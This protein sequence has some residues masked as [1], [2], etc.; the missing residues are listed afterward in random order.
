MTS[1]VRIFG[2][3]AVAATV[4]SSL[5]VLGAAL[6]PWLRTGNATRSAFGLARSASVLGLF[7]GA[8]RRVCLALWY[9]LPFL[10]AATW[11]AGAARRP[12][13]TALLGGIVGLTSLVAGTLV[14]VLA[15][16]APGPVVAIG[17]GAAAIGSAVLLARGTMRA[18]SDIFIQEGATT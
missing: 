7:D 8:P 11:T 6:L 4:A 3:G 12:L 13:L 1:S 15:R 9:L 16:P 5:A 2:R 14:V 17:A 18:G 10:V